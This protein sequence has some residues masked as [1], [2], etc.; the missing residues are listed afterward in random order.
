[1]HSSFCKCTP[2][3]RLLVKPSPIPWRSAPQ[4]LKNPCLHLPHSV[5][6]HHTGKQAVQYECRSGLHGRHASVTSSVCAE[7]WV[8]TRFVAASPQELHAFKFVYA[9]GSFTE[10]PRMQGRSPGAL[11]PR[12]PVI[13]A[14]SPGHQ[15]ANPSFKRTR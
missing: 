6:A 13:H 5:R 12:S 3:Y 15:R 4:V 7:S 11:S 9:S 2:L 1:M 8:S 10:P 14:G